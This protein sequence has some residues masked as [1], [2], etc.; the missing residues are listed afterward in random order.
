MIVPIAGQGV[1]EIPTRQR[2]VGGEPANHFHQQSVQLLP[3]PAG[4]FS[5]V[6]ALTPSGVLISRI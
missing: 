6:V 2:R 1:I 5:F 3:V 4:F